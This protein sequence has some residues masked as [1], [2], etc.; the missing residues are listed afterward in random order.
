MQLWSWITK[1]PL[2]FSAAAET[3]YR[4]FAELAEGFLEDNFKYFCSSA[5][6]YSNKKGFLKL[7]GLDTNYT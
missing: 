3:R 5:R 2:I 1:R 7:I 4:N 6:D